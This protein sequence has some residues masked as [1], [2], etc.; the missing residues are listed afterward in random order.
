MSS[1]KNM[2]T[3]VGLSGSGKNGGSCGGTYG[4]HFSNLYFF[5]FFFF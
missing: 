5:D 2:F 4:R 3:G 1:V